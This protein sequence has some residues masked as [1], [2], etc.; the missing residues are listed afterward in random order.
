MIFISYQHDSPNI[1]LQSSTQDKEL[2]V[3]GKKT[4]CGRGGP[5]QGRT[6]QL[7][8]QFQKVHNE[9]IHIS[10]IICTQKVM[11]MNMYLYRNTCMYAIQLINKRGHE[12]F[13]GEG[14]IEDL[15]DIKKKEEM[16]LNFNLKNK[17]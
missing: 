17:Q 12:K 11:F 6:I 16:Q 4:E 13:E 1:S 14:C 2:Q 10:N 9:N 15:G 5:P 8:L 3:T 7:V